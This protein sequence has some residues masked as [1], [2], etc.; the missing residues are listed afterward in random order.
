MKALFVSGPRDGGSTE[1]TVD[2]P[3]P[4]LVVPLFEWDDLV[5]AKK[6]LHLEPPASSIKV[7]T[8]TLTMWNVVPIYVY[9]DVRDTEKDALFKAAVVKWGLNQFLKA[10]Q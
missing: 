5:F 3:P 4:I 8:Y 7:G 1:I 6:A 10:N 2:P 9:E